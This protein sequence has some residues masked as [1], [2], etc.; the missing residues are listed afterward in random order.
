MADDHEGPGKGQ[1]QF[2]K[3]AEKNASLPSEIIG[4][5]RENKKLWLLPPMVVFLLIGVF[6]L[7]SQTAA[8]PFVY[9]FF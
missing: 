7:L 5:L 1:S 9:T 8:A 4:F 2:E 3:V 6:V